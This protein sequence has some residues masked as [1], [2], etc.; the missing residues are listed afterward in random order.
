MSDDTTPGLA[1]GFKISSTVGICAPVCDVRCRLLPAEHGA[2]TAALTLRCQ[3]MS[4]NIGMCK[5]TK[6][7]SKIVKSWRKLKKATK[8]AGKKGTKVDQSDVTL[9]SLSAATDL[10]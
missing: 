2:G 3:S 5:M 1:D 6:K 4:P 7:K 10:I 9:V 8:K